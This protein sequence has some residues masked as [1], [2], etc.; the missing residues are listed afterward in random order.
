MPMLLNPL[1]A[2]HLD[3]DQFAFGIAEIVQL[4]SK[5]QSHCGIRS[6]KLAVLVQLQSWNRQSK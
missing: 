5:T 6:R 2:S 4:L 3:D 1:P